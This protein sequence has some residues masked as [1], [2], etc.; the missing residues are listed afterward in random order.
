MVM[1]V[2][3]KQRKYGETFLTKVRWTTNRLE[4]AQKSFF[5]WGTTDGGETYN[6][7]LLGVVNGLLSRVGL[8]LVAHVGNYDRLYHY[9]LKRKWW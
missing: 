8:V 6:L 7:S 3:G 4:K 2:M 5:V 1:T 9:R